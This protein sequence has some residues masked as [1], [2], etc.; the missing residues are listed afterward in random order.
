MNDPV[1]QIEDL[2]VAYRRR[3]E[4]LTVLSGVGVEIRAGEAFGLV[5]ESGCGKTTAALAIMRYL[6]KNGRVERGAIRLDGQDLLTLDEEA[7]RRWRGRKLA[8][9]YQE[10][11]AALNPSLR[12]GEQVAEI[13]RFHEG[14]SRHERMERA[15]DMLTRVALP[16]PRRMLRRYPHQLSGGQQQRVVIAMALAT[17]PRLLVLDEPTTGLDATVEAEVLDLIGA[18]RAEFDAAILFISHNL[19]VVARVCDRVGVLYAG[20]I[21]EE[22]PA[23][24]VLADPRHPYT[25]GLVRCVP[26]LGTRKDS[27]PLVPIPGS[28]PPL[29]AELPGCY[30]APRCPLARTRCREGEPTLFALGGA[31]ASRCYYHDEVPA[32]PVPA[33]PP[34][35]RAAREQFERRLLDVR[36]LSKSFGEALACDDVTFAVGAAEIFG[37]VGESG[38]G[39]T[40]LARCV[41]GLTPR[42]GGNVLFE[43]A[44]LAPSVQRR[45]RSVLRRLQMVFQHPDSTLNPRHTARYVLARAIARLGGTRRVDELAREVLL[46]PKHLDLRAPELSG[47]LKQRVAIGRAFAGSPALVL[48]DEPVS[49]LD[50]SVQAGILNLLAELQA[51]E[52]VSFVFI[53]HDLAVVRYLADR[54]GVMYLG[55]LVEIGGAD[56]VFRPPQHPYTE[57]LL[58]AIP[59]LDLDRPRERIR[60][61]GPVPSL[62]ALPSGCRFHPRCPRKLGEICEREQPPL[63]EVGDGHLIRCHIT[64][65]ELRARQEAAYLVSGQNQEGGALDRL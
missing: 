23:R 6:P 27:T 34:D 11:A 31:R 28:L 8:M 17:N 54:I 40:T 56:E 60:L 51:A 18:V 29:G 25:L 15:R 10:P 35:V 9:V 32:L 53:S 21:V 45:D 7:L 3:G 26:R 55:Q 30:Y 19:A 57:A 59:T 4:R 12:I 41:A 46:E 1:L 52:R 14:A 24:E 38:S 5:G 13:F 49:A 42:D 48:C 47:G 64:P 20:R 22:G 33:P 58:S 16:D 44:P 37:V 36:S 43:G 63:R 2:T 62:A 50:V 65:E 39:K 61:L